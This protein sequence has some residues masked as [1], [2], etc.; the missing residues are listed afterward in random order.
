[1]ESNLLSHLI[2]AKKRAIREPGILLPIL[3]FADDIVFMGTDLSVIQHIL[4]TLATFCAQNNL[5]VS[6]QKTK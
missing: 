2:A 4:D 3:L 5:L 6:L 1:M